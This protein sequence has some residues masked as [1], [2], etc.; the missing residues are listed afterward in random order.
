MAKEVERMG[1]NFFTDRYL[2]GWNLF[3]IPGSTAAVIR[4]TKKS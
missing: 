3:R 4:Q 1:K 2:V